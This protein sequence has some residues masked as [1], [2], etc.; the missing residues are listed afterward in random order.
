M[1][2]KLAFNIEQAGYGNGSFYAPV[3]AEYQGNQCLVL[4]GPGGSGKTTLLRLLSRQEHSSLWLD[5]TVHTSQNFPFFM[6]QIYASEMVLV[7]DTNQLEELEGFWSGNNAIL[8]VL[9]AYN[10][11]QLADWPKRYRKLGLL[12]HFALTPHFK[13]SGI[14]L[15]DEPEAGLDD[16]YIDLL[17]EKIIQLKT[18]KIIVVSTH[19]VSFMEHIADE[20]LFLKYG[21]VI[22]ITKKDL[23]FTSE[24]QEV[25]YLIKMGC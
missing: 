23:F 12:S 14:I 2:N 11:Q 19:H 18:E 5:G 25:Q 6:E 8:S 21:K 10:G 7:F 9:G 22:S 16:V 20:I 1:T 4:I 13:Q 3:S 17:A 15:L 24:D